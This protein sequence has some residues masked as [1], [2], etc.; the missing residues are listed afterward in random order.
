MRGKFVV[1]L[2]GLLVDL[3]DDSNGHRHKTLMAGI[4]M[5]DWPEV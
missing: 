4:K 3:R 2:V 5:L 1:E